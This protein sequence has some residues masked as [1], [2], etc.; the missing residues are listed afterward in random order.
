MTISVTLKLQNPNRQ[1]K[2]E[3]RVD[4]LRILYKMNQNILFIYITLHWY[5]H[6]Y[7]D[8][9]YKNFTSIDNWRYAL[10]QKYYKEILILCG[11]VI[12]ERYIP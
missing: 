9:K 8:T 6:F 11:G 4:F 5:R 7:F 2:Q 1:W 10:G 12:F 3:L